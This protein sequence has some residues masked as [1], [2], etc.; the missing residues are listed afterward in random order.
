LRSPANAPS[1]PGPSAQ[2]LLSKPAPLPTKSTICRPSELNGHRGFPRRACAFVVSRP[3]YVIE[4]STFH[5]NPT[6]GRNSQRYRRRYTFHDQHNSR[7]EARDA[8]AACGSRRR[9]EETTF[10]MK[11]GSLRDTGSF[12]VKRASRIFSKSE[13]EPRISIARKAKA[14]P[15]THTRG[16]RI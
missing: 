13:N 7:A 11:R 3:S 8:L 12:K 9:I 14:P 6:K 10:A 15:H 1:N 16:T 2:R 4:V 5:P